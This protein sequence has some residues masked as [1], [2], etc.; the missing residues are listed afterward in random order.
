MNLTGRYFL[1]FLF[2][3]PLINSAQQAE[4]SLQVKEVALRTKAETDK[5]LSLEFASDEIILITKSDLELRSAPGDSGTVT[6]KLE[7]GVKVQQ[8]DIIGSHYL[9]CFMGKCGYVPKTSILKVHRSEVV[10][11]NVKDSLAPKAIKS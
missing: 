8:L 9:V 4:D 6:G 3:I 11:E 7:K 5:D 10:P 1:F 2:F